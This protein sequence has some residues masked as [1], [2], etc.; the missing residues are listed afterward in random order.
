MCASIDAE[1]GALLPY[2]KKKKLTCT[3]VH[4]V[5]SQIVLKYHH[6]MTSLAMRTNIL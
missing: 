6:Y 1:A 3:I 5:Y 4:A 2:Q